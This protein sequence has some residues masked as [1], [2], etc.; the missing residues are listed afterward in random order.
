MAPKKRVRWTRSSR[1]KMRASSNKLRE[2]KF[3]KQLKGR[4]LSVQP[5]L[6]V[7]NLLRDVKDLQRAA[8]KKEKVEKTKEVNFT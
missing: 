7:E 5:S 8:S 2:K 1:P 6:P 3:Q 4:H